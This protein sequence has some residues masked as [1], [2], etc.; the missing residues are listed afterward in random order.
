MR[1][2]TA[3]SVSAHRPSPVFFIALIVPAVA[4]AACSVFATPNVPTAAPGPT[5]LPATA[6]PSAATSPVPT[7]TVTAISTVTPTATSTASTS[8]G[9]PTAIQA[10]IA[11]SDR[12][13]GVK[14]DPGIGVDK[15]TFT[16]G[17]SS[18]QPSGT[19]PTGELRPTSPP[20]S[21][22]GSGQAVTVDGHRFIA[23]TFR[24]MAVADEQG[25]ASYAGP[26][27]IHPNALAIRELRQTEAFEGVVTWIVGVDGPGCVAL[28]RLTGPDR[29]VI[30]VSQ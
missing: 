11:P 14:V 24:G 28:S 3:P 7:P 13:T 19:D 25:N 9:C 12:L 26:T 29:I 8:T 30:A 5:V 23:I 15:I 10:G 20:F 16:F 17:T 27:D 1:S 6:S 18:G 22:G 21:L 2:P 4:L